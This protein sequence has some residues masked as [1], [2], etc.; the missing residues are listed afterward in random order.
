MEVIGISSGRLL[1]FAPPSRGCGRSGRIQK[2][3][4]TYHHS[5]INPPGLKITSQERWQAINSQAG[6]AKKTRFIRWALGWINIERGP[7]LDPFFDGLPRYVLPLG[8]LLRFDIYRRTQS[9]T[10]LPIIHKVTVVV[11][12]EDCRA[13]VGISGSPSPVWSPEAQACLRDPPRCSD[14]FHWRPAEYQSTKS[15]ETPAPRVLEALKGG[16][17]KRIRL[18]SAFISSDLQPSTR[19]ASQPTLL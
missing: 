4:F 16:S 14:L 3:V 6:W 12:L 15:L 11:H 9:S 2:L 19:L 1:H 17:I 8:K 7:L 10:N 5:S 18:Q 13:K